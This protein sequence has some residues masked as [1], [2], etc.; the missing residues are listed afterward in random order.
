VALRARGAAPEARR[1]GRELAIGHSG[2]FSVQESLLAVSLEV[3]SALHDKKKM[4]KKIRLSVRES[5]LAVGV[6]VPRALLA[7]DMLY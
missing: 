4:R 2:P 7:A 3:P 5:L 1:G 6:E